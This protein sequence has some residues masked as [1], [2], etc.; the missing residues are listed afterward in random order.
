[1]VSTISG[2]YGI[3]PTTKTV[4]DVA[5]RVEGK[6]KGI[7]I[8][9]KGWIPVLGSYDFKLTDSH[10]NPNHLILQEYEKG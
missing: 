6:R 10:S 2:K 7:Y 5:I 9:Y 1:M 8:L 3:I 4:G